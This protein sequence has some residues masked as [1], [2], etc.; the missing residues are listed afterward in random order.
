MLHQSSKSRTVVAWRLSKKA[1]SMAN[2][3][4]GYDNYFVHDSVTVETTLNA[5]S[6]AG[7][8]TETTRLTSGTGHAVIIV[9]VLTLA[10]ACFVLL[11][12]LRAFVGWSSLRRTHPL[13]ASKNFVASKKPRRRIDKPNS[14]GQPT[15]SKSFVN[16]WSVS[17]Y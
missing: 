10:P 12:C 11:C 9:L 16:S 13:V 6:A 1:M 14:K 5:I 15:L 3:T 17:N 4:T 8:T 2:A 7:L